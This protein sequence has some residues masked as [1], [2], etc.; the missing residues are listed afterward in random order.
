MLIINQEISADFCEHLPHLQILDIR[1]NKIERLPDEIAQLQALVRLDLSNNSLNS[2]PNSLA[3]L[4]HLVS[5][6]LEGNPIRS[7]RR[8]VIQG[9]TIRILK[10]LRDRAGLDDQG[11]PDVGPVKNA[12]QIGGDDTVFPDQ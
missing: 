7:I 8:D 5:L 3:S 1:D 9:G 2:L 4:A 10:M 6:Q 12:A 11:R